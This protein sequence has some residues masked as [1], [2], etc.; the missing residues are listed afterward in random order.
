[1]NLRNLVL[2]LA[3][4]VAAGVAFAI[5]SKGLFVLAAC[6]LWSYRSLPAL[7]TSVITGCATA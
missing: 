2:L 1:M 7:L 4:G 3:A 5:N 6:V